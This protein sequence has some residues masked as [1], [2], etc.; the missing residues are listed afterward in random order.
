L[1]GWKLAAARLLWAAAMILVLVLF[2]RGM[3]M[4]IDDLSNAPAETQEALTR[5][6]ITIGVYVGYIITLRATAMLLFVGG[7][8]I[9][10]WHKSDDWMTIF[11][12]LTMLFFGATNT[13]F[14]RT[15]VDGTVLGLISFYA[16]IIGPVA[17]LFFLY[18]FPDGQFIPPWTRWVGI[19][20]GLW[21]FLWPL[22]PLLYIHTWPPFMTA[23]TYIGVFS[24]GVYAQVYRQKC[25]L[26]PVQVQ[27][28]KWVY[29][30]LSASFLGLLLSFISLALFPQLNEPGMA[31]LLYMLINSLVYLTTMALV[32]L[33]IT[34]SVLH[35]RLWDI[36]PLVNRTLVYGL[37]TGLLGLVYV[38]VVVLSQQILV[39]ITGKT[40]NLVVVATTLAIATLF[41]PL[42][43]RLQTF[44]DR[45]FY[46]EQVDFRQAFLEFSRELR[47]I[48]NL[49]ELLQVLSARTAELLHVVHGV[50]FLA[51]EKG[52][53]GVAQAHNLSSKE[54][55][56]LSLK[57][58]SLGRLRT[59][60]VM[61]PLNDSLFKLL[62]PLMAPKRSGD[63]LVGVLALGP[64][65]SGQGYSVN[66]QRLLKG[67]A[68]QAG[69]AIY[70][71]QII[72]EKEEEA[73]RKEE[74][75]HQLEAYRKSPIGRAETLAQE[76][77]AHPETSLGELYSLGF[78]AAQDPNAAA[79]MSNLPKV[80]AGLNAGAVTDL[81]EGYSYLFSGRL[82][83][84][85]MP[86]GLRKMIETLEKAPANNWPGASRALQMYRLS[87]EALN[88]DSVFQISQLL[89]LLRDKG[90]RGQGDKGTSSF[91]SAFAGVMVELRAVAEALYAYERVDAAQ[92]KLAYLANA[93]EQLRRV[94]YLAQT[95]L[96]GIDQVVI[97][98]IIE[99]WLAVVT[100]AMS[101]LQTRARILCRLLTRNTWQDEVIS[102]VLNVRNEGRGAAVDV[103]VSLTPSKQYTVMGEATPIERLTSGEETQVELRA[104][105]RLKGG[106]RFRARFVIRYADP[107]GPKQ[108]EHFADEVQL[109]EAGGE[110]QFIP[111]PYVA[112]TPLQ[113]D[114]PLFF[115]REDVVAAIQENL[116]AGHRNNLVLI[117][118]RRTGKTSLL[119]Q[120]PAQL[121]DEYLPVYIDGQTLGLDPGLPN[122]F[123]TLATEIAF[124]L[125]DRNFIIDLPELDDFVES[126]AAAFEHRFLA[127][128]RKIIGDRHLLILLDE[129]EELETAVQRG[130]IDPS[131]FGFLRHLIQHYPNLSVIFCGTHRLEEL[132]G[133]YW[134]VLFNIS[135][136]RHIAFLAQDEALR[137]MQEPVAEYGMRYDDLALDKMWRV[138]AGH[139]YFLQLLCHSLVNRHN[140]TE[141]NYITIADVNVAL[142]EILASGE[143]HFIYLW[144][145]ATV[146]ERLVLV[147][148]S[149]MMPLTG[150]AAPAQVLDYLVERG[151]TIERREL[152]ESLHRLTLRDILQSSNKADGALGDTY[153][154]QLGLLGLWVEKYKSISRVVGK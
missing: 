17:F 50:I 27:Q 29:F 52:E 56:A 95:E 79:M 148:L 20:W 111:N 6:G 81:A 32:P 66:D 60:G 2:I 71:A 108:V 110:F 25:V 105:P 24:T 68:N 104:R 91:L 49:R 30:G 135:L 112:G 70:V 77:L 92:D 76:L 129:F 120:L 84:E 133:D 109:L 65:L 146:A 41:Q 61:L 64:R 89:S 141:R 51:D 34:V 11:V 145:E 130:S 15:G 5:L 54:S 86:I 57:A 136:Y 125:E 83:P 14:V 39:F 142:D 138:T 99:S 33:T 9:I 46:R 124:A 59:G 12:S 26:K 152:S 47:A 100:G 94:N 87:Q 98:R 55:E 154:W 38:V 22:V 72:V 23:L 123:L 139:P 88:A 127:E 43:R 126:P 101:E 10:F 102:L 31:N 140:K 119:K 97:Q 147:A 96:G 63:E 45:S 74:A 85:V 137:L 16:V 75:E 117:G 67:L 40:S 128:V 149:R 13:D 107:R 73:K 53:F 113:I 115:G 116:T 42:R 69:T 1:Q 106:N 103:S 82:T 7:A 18:L 78:Q 37:V 21:L 4:M 143:A 134:N 35:Y 44:V 121:G 58:Y 80:L 3:G 36:D 90:T 62:V 28:V 122:F 153:R 19:G 114:S 93:V 8:A 150:Q 144:A 48:I 151:V 131:V 132:A 118:Q